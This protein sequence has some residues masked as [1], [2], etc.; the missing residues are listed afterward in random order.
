MKR[1]REVPKYTLGGWE[2]ASLTD[3]EEGQ[4]VEEWVAA[5]GYNPHET[6]VFGDD[7]VFGVT[8]HKQTSGE[9]RLI[10]ISDGDHWD[11]VVVDDL[12]SYLALLALLAPIAQ[13]AALAAVRLFTLAD[14]AGA[15]LEKM[16]K[17]QRVGVYE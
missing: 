1:T 14:N 6:R 4:A 9:G 8:Y 12:P 15:L 5:N 7:S 10:D 16:A 17:E 11:C 2:T 3:L 13:A